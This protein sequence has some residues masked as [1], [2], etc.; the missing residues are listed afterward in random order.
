MWYALIGHSTCIYGVHVITGQIISFLT[1]YAV[2]VRRGSARYG[3]GGSPQSIKTAI[4]IIIKA[5]L[6]W[7]VK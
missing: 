4:K 6:N 1:L 5:A 3:D 7:P 2:C